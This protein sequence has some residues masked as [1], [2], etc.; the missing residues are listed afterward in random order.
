LYQKDVRKNQ[1]RMCVHKEK[2]GLLS[3]REKRVFEHML[4]MIETGLSKEERH[5]RSSRRGK[6]QWEAQDEKTE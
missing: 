2:R 1:R 5:Q 3:R 4:R 6:E